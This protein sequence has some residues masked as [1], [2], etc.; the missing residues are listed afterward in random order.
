MKG[1]IR[2]TV[3][4]CAA[5][6][7][8]A[9][10]APSLAQEVTFAYHFEPGAGDRYAVKFNQEVD[11]GGG[12]MSIS[13]IADMEVS[14][15]C[16]AAK[17]GK[18]SMEMKFDK[19]DVSMT[20]MGTTSASPLG[21]QITGQTIMFTADA[22]GDV[23]DVTPVGA[24]DSWSTAQQLVKPVIESWY[25]HLP[26]KAV[27]VGGT[28]EKAGEKEKQSSGMESTT[29]ATFKFKEMKKDKG[30]DVAVVEQQ[31][32]TA[33]GGTSTTPMGVY[34]VAGS[35]KGKG[36]FSFDPAKSRVTKVKAKID[37]NMDMTPQSGGEP[38]K[39]IVTNNL[40]RTLL[41]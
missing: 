39:T 20:M 25:P 21:E 17:D 4:S 29:S 10:A 19:V 34:T 6:A 1:A 36:E 37:I 40:E 28:W 31:L 3:R 11:M 32:D 35:G 2:F 7:F 13:N 5:I 33:I 15:K 26:N 24:F 38:V 27:A 30:H 16:V 22:S 41:E 18:F 14:V 23:S 8:V 12:K 9:A